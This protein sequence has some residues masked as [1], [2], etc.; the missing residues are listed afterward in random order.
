MKKLLIIVSLISGMSLC[1]QQIETPKTIIISPINSDGLEETANRPTCW[2]YIE[3]SDDHCCHAWSV[4]CSNGYGWSGEMMCNFGCQLAV[5]LGNAWNRTIQ[6]NGGETVNSGK[7]IIASFEFK[8]FIIQKDISDKNPLDVIL[9]YKQMSKYLFY[10]LDA[11][12]TI[13]VGNYIYIYQPGIYEIINNK[14]T[15]SYYYK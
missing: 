13:T 3:M 5:G 1:A 9:E 6:P 4:M 2:S 11:P 15:V 8:P 7:P 12:S 14:M 10:K